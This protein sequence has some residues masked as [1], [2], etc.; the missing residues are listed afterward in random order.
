LAEW[1]NIFCLRVSNYGLQ[2]TSNFKKWFEIIARVAGDLIDATVSY[3][4]RIKY[5]DFFE[6]VVSRNR[7]L[8]RNCGHEMEL[9]QLYHPDKGILWDLQDRLSKGVR[10]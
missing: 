10:I 2:S 7:L 6:G 9:R 5:E 3:A 8:C 1:C 4:K